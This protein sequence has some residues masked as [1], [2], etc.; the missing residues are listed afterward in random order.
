MVLE[1]FI[2][3]ISPNVPGLGERGFVWLALR[4]WT[5]PWSL[6]PCVCPAWAAHTS[7]KALEK[8]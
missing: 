6:S 8:D 5:K 3:G 2:W 1:G 7:L 4:V